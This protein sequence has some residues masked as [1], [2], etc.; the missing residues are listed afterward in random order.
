M[1]A[2]RRSGLGYVRTLSEVS[3]R[4]NIGVRQ[5]QSG[6]SLSIGVFEVSRSRFC[7]GRG[8]LWIQY[9][10]LVLRSVLNSWG[11]RQNGKREGA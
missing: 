10:V 3:C 2:V 8:R 4:R 7:G 5:R 11:Q 1:K 9:R 6:K